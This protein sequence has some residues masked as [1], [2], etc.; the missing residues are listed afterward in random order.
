MT[1]LRGTEA[2]LSWISHHDDVLDTFTMWALLTREVRLV[3][4]EGAWL[5]CLQ[6]AVAIVMCH[7]KAGHC[8]ADLIDI[9]IVSATCAQCVHNLHNTLL[10]VLCTPLSVQDPYVPAVNV[11][12]AC[13]TI[14]AMHHCGAACQRWRMPGMPDTWHQWPHA[15][16]SAHLLHHCCS[17]LGRCGNDDI[18]R[19]GLKFCALL[20]ALIAVCALDGCQEAGKCFVFC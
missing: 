12:H 6:I 11:A 7:L 17:A 1:Q 2:H 16:V 5:V 4:S 18:S 10:S 13:R 3:R 19:P 15:S 14:I 8:Q 20:P 9:V